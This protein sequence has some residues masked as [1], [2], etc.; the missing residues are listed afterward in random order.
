MTIELAID[1]EDNIEYFENYKLQLCQFII[2]SCSYSE[3][4]K[5]W[6]KIPISTKFHKLNPNEILEIL[7]EISRLENFIYELKLIKTPNVSVFNYIYNKQF[8]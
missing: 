2:H 8:K 1:I 6:G 5:T 4:K 3:T 7:N